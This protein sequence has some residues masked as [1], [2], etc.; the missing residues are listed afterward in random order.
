M[1][2]SHLAAGAVLA[3]AASC[4]DS[5]SPTPTSGTFSFTYGGEVISGTYSASGTLPAIG[6]PS[7]S[8]WAAGF[9]SDAD[10]ESGAVAIVP[11]ANARYDMSILAI[12]GV[13]TGSR[14][15]DVDCAPDSDSGCTG[16]ALLFNAS[17]N[18]DATGTIFCGLTAGSVTVTTLTTTRLA[19]T[20]Q[21]SGSCATD[22]SEGS[23]TVSNGSFDVPIFSEGGPGGTL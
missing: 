22:T 17:D 3:F 1:K 9:R 20:F 10:Q 18:P 19:G 21:G 23:F 14:S 5:T 12:D 7:A 4:S 2:F 11:K 13:T 15:I 6:N 8:E 16:F